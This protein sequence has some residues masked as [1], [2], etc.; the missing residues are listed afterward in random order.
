MRST[1]S[2]SGRV[3]R[4]AW[5]AEDLRGGLG[6]LGAGLDLV[7]VGLG[8][9]DQRG[10]GADLA[11]E[12]VGGFGGEGWVGGCQLFDEGRAGLGVDV[13]GGAG[14][15]FA[16]LA[17]QVAHLGDGVG[18]QAGD[19]GFEGAGVDDLA[20]RGVGGQRE[21]VAGHVKGA[22]LEGALVGFRL[23]SLGTGDAA[24]RAAQER[25][26]WCAGRRRRDF[27]RSAA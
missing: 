9:F 7:V 19:L 4:W 21:Q 11:G 6:E 24:A 20:E 1:R 12:Q 25:P 14:G 3:P 23:Q 2:T 27:R 18:E 13:P 15:G 22:G 26:R 5:S 16:Q 8:V 17:A 10:R